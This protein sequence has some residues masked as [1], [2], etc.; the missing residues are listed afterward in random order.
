MSENK[1]SQDQI[2]TPIQDMVASTQEN[3]T[4]G[5]LVGSIIIVLIIIIGGLYYIG[6]VISIKKN[7]IKDTQMIEEQTNIKEIEET[8][9]QSNTDD[10]PSIE[11]DI[12]S[13]DIDSVGDELK[14]I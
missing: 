7:Q 5:P 11:Q 4:T 9:K 3:G 8:T 6:N 1:N 12:I 13:T 2:R 14:E 10:L